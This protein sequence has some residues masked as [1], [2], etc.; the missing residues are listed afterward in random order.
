MGMNDMD[1]DQLTAASHSRVPLLQ[2]E[3]QAQLLGTRGA[4][5]SISIMVR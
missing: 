5:V 3:A 1:G 4:R 2:A